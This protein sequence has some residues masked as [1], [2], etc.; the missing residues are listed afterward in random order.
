LTRIPG[1]PIYQLAPTGSALHQQW[2]DVTGTVG[3]FVLAAV[4]TMSGIFPVVLASMSVMLAAYWGPTR[5]YA[6]GAVHETKEGNEKKTRKVVDMGKSMIC[7]LAKA[8]P[9]AVLFH[10]IGIDALSL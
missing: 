7:E 8:A 3:G 1:H 10:T 5:E 2:W 6:Y 4:T 9:I